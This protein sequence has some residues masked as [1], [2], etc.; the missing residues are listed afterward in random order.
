MQKNFPSME[1]NIHEKKNWEWSIHALIPMLEKYIR[2]CTEKLRSG[3]CSTDFHQRCCASNNS[4]VNG[5]MCYVVR[6]SATF[7][8]FI[9]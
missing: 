9:T 2:V 8:K 7:T 4:N 6:N 5:R 3:G 1:Y